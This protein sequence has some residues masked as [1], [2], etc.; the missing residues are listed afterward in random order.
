MSVNK[1]EVTEIIIKL[2]EVLEE[3]KQYLTDLDAAIGDGDHGTNM[4][5]GFQSVRAKLEAADCDTI[6]DVIKTTAMTLISTVGGASGPL[7]GTL[8]LR[9]SGELKGLEQLDLS[10]F[11][12]VFGIGIE[13][14]KQR[15]RSEFGEKTM[16]DVLIPVQ[17]SLL[18]SVQAGYSAIESFHR[19]AA[20]AREAVEATK[21]IKA[22]K[23]RASYLGERSIGHMDPGAMSSCLMIE[24]ID[25][26]LSERG[27]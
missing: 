3:N 12:K 23:G 14:V 18:D 15:G 6:A 20:T 4:S 16:L 22:T 25:R 19:A 7:Y 1:Q 9:I 24:T 13:A 27:A 5:R 11:Y 10:Q 17:Q 26:Y 21:L 8:F 2:A